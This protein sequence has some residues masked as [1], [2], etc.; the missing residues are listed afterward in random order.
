MIW[1]ADVDS[2]GSRQCDGMIRLALDGLRW[3]W[4]NMNL[5]TDQNLFFQI[6][7]GN[8]AV[9]GATMT[10]SGGAVKFDFFPERGRACRGFSLSPLR[11]EGRGEGWKS[12]K[13]FNIQH[14]TSNTQ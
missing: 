10:E 14:S 3:E 9:N 2:A 6:G 7:K 1:F 11:G 13:T 4:F 8:L 12:G 5:P